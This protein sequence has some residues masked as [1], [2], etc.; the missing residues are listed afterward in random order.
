ME[1]SHKQENETGAAILLYMNTPSLVLPFG[2]YKEVDAYKTGKRSNQSLWESI[3]FDNASRNRILDIYF[4]I[5]V[6]TMKSTL[7]RA[8]R[9]LSIG[10]DSSSAYVFAVGVRA[11]RA[12]FICRQ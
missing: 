1:T 5:L 11:S 8:H 4:P 6:P 12:K 2:L 9:T 10:N 3:L 7:H